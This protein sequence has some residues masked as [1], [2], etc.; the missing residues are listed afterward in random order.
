MKNFS[1]EDLIA[2]HL[3]ELPRMRAWSLRRELEHNTELAAESE[4]IAETLDGL[5]DAAQRCFV[6]GR[7][8]AAD[9]IDRH[10]DLIALL[11]RVERREGQAGFGP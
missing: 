11:D 7:R 1:E 3:N 5:L 8:G 10:I 9:R 4:A 2:Y 6:R